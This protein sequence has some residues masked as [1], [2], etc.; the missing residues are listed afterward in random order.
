KLILEIE[1]ATS[2]K[3]TDELSDVGSRGVRN[4]FF[5]RKQWSGLA[6]QGYK[7]IRD[8]CTGEA[9]VVPDQER[10][11]LLTQAGLIVA[12]GKYT[13]NEAWWVLNNRWKYRTKMRKRIGGKKLAKSAFYKFLS[14]P[15]Y[16]GVMEANVGGKKQTSKGT[17]QPM[18]TREEWDQIQISLGKNTSRNVIKRELPYRGI[19]KCGE[20]G[21]S[22]VAQE[23]W[24][25]ICP[26]CKYKFHKGIKT[27]SCPGCGLAISEMKDK[28]VL[29]Y[30]YYGCNKKKKKSNNSKCYEK[31]I[32]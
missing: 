23:K 13:G 25:I 20:C 8:E 27:T 12:E 18:F 11:D 29:H 5:E 26:D 9:K 14:N 19:L 1:F 22:I 31:N 28:K 24:Q 30:I 17:H 3:Y 7:N 21:S 10:F 4:K 15:F 6:P 32:E 2:K 16:Y